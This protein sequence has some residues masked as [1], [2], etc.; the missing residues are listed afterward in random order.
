VRCYGQPSGL[1]VDLQRLRLE[2]GQF[3]KKPVCLVTYGGN[4]L[5]HKI[6]KY[7]ISVQF[8]SCG[9]SPW[10]P[11]E[12]VPGGDGRERY[13]DSHLAFG[14]LFGAFVVGNWAEDHV[15]NIKSFGNYSRENAKLVIYQYEGTALNYLV[16]LPGSNS[17]AKLHA[18]KILALAREYS[19]GVELWEYIADRIDHPEKLRWRE[20]HILQ[21]VNE[22]YF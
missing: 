7:A 14:N 8:S 15:D 3:V 9:S 18:Q 10:R 20:G 1:V 11:I 16:G 4:H 13:L 5:F 2:P 22:F 21:P 19:I 12:V 17:D 6:G